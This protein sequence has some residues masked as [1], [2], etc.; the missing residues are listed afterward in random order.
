MSG[1]TLWI[2][3]L[4]QGEQLDAGRAMMFKRETN[5]LKPRARRSSVRR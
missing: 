4:V 2:D 1:E 5:P 3:R